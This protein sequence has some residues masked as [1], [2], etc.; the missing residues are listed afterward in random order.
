MK[1]RDRKPGITGQEE[2]PKVAM[3]TRL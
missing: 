1:E 3:S 2:M